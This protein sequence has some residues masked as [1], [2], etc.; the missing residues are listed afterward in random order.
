MLESSAFH[1]LSPF[2]PRWLPA[3]VRFGGSHFQDLC[4]LWLKY[5]GPLVSMYQ[6]L[7]SL[8]PLLVTLVLPVFRSHPG[9]RGQLLPP[10]SRSL[11]LGVS[12][13][14]TSLHLSATQPGHRGTSG[15][16]ANYAPAIE[17]HQFCVRSSIQTLPSIVPNPSPG[18]C[19][20]EGI[21]LAALLP[22]SKESTD[23][24]RCTLS[25]LYFEY[26]GH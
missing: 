21:I 14:L 6:L 12:S 10:V 7:S 26:P 8:N 9:I 22:I 17:N 13:V 15:M 3:C 5:L 20:L 11:P 18:P 24:G 23:L 16:P 2:T 25:R 4:W 1:S 19:T